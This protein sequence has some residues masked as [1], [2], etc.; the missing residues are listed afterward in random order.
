MGDTKWEI[1][2]ADVVSRRGKPT[3]QAVVFLFM[4]SG[5]ELSAQRPSICPANIVHDGKMD[6][7]RNWF[8]ACPY[9]GCNF[10]RRLMKNMPN[11]SCHDIDHI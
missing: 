10:C 6:V 8:S 1:W 2:H 4:D 9:S 11:I 7:F 5:M 3:P